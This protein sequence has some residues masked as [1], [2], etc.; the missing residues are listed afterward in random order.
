[1]K[2][3]E[4]SGEHYDV[5]VCGGGPAG[6][7]AAMAA[8]MNGARTLLLEAEELL[9]GSAVKRMWIGHNRLFTNGKRRGGVHDLLVDKLEQYGSIA[10]RPGIANERD[11]D[12]LNTHPEYLS[13]CAFEL[14]EECGCE[15]LVCSRVEDV[16]LDGRR[17]TGVLVRDRM[18]SRKYTASVIIDATGDGDVAYFA[19]C[20]M[21]RGREYDG[22]YM[23]ITVPFSLSGVDLERFNDALNR[24]PRMMDTY[25]R[26]AELGDYA[27]SQ[28]YWLYFPG[29]IPGVSTCNNNGLGAGSFDGTNARDLTTLERVGL[30][31]AFDFVRWARALELPG[32]EHAHLM[33]CGT[34][35]VRE[36]RR[37]V[38]EY[39]LTL[40][41]VL[42][43]AEREFGDVIARRYGAV[44]TVYYSHPMR[45][46]I[47]YPY[48]C[49]LPRRIDGLL[50]AGR[51]SS[52]T[53][54]GQASGK[55]MG[56]V[57][58]IGQAAGVAA[59]L[60]AQQGVQP[61]QA[62]VAQVQKRLIEMGVCLNSRA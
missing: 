20:E 37:I 57:M 50:V 58:E 30:Q 5:I 8:S 39:V 3:A 56:N 43:D 26:R 44:D 33:R 47:G 49:L 12:N 4:E 19:G 62:D 27:L 16:L 7:G 51:C 15:Y 25:L 14:L 48:R 21:V 54:L 55:S 11:G 45:Q 9:G 38:G 22:I 34:A 2:H 17:L 10:A 1:M 13:L 61:R 29:T 18:G 41:D 40:R 32:F 23:P 59:A 31:I 24:D 36:T 46:G 35:S 28:R 42:N 53:H 60:C 52:A 6:L